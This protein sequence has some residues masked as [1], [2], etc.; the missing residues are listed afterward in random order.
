MNMK[1]I[2]KNKEEI[3]ISKNLATA[4]LSSEEYQKQ[5]DDII[6]SIRSENDKYFLKIYKDTEGL[7]VSYLERLEK[8]T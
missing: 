3:E 8:N 7:L 6:Y 5:N 2:K 1:D 4:F